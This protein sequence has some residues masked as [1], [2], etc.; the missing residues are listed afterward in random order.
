MNR[1]LISLPYE[2]G[3]KHFET[4]AAH[5]KLIR[6]CGLLFSDSRWCSGG[7]GEHTWQVKCDKEQ[8]I[9]LVLK[10]AKIVSDLTAANRSS[11]LLKLTEYEKEALGITE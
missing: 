4:Q 10:G 9:M 3:G 2:K 8:L 7:P 1:Y 11:G 5:Y 6:E